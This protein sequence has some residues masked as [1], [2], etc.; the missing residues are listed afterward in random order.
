MTAM[1]YLKK[2]ENALSIA[3]NNSNLYDGK[4]GALRIA[5]EIGTCLAHYPKKQRDDAI[6]FSYD[7]CIKAYDLRPPLDKK[8]WDDEVV[9]GVNKILDN[10]TG[11][12]KK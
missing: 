10:K 12:L 5:R 4:E 9:K 11:G 3:L 2:V 8:D 7:I 6:Q 1:D